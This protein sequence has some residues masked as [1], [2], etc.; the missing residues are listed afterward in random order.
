[1][2]TY[3]IYYAERDPGTTADPE[4]YTSPAERLSSLG[5]SG[6]RMD[7][8]EWE[9]EVEGKDASEALD[10]FFRE[11]IRD[12]SELMWVDEHG[13]S[14]PAEGLSYEPA[15]T[16]IWIE[17]GKLMEYQGLDEGTPGMV[18]C[19]LCEGS[20]EVTADVAD[21]YVDERGEDTERQ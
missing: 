15:R 2:P 11:H 19:P 18:S 7:A 9:E 10:A 20:G 17:N 4:R 8:T 21:Q 3:R 1:M 6:G 14:H 5:S 16:Y 13:A 12:N